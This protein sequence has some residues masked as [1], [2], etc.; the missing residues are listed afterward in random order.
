MSEDCFRLRTFHERLWCGFAEV[1]EAS[2]EECGSVVGER[3]DRRRITS[4]QIELR[5]YSCEELVAA[6]NAAPIT[7]SFAVPGS[8]EGQLE[9]QV[10]G[11]ADLWGDDRSRS[12]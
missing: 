6:V 3:W 8:L 12:F 1:E 4:L 9:A 5:R 10:P 7:G 11:T 2:I